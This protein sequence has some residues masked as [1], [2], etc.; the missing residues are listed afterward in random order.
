MSA[1]SP[2]P[3]GF[4]VVA[5][6]QHYGIR[7]RTISML[8]LKAW[9]PFHEDRN[10]S[11]SVNLKKGA[12]HCF[13]CERK[14]NM[15]DFVR[16]IENYD[17]ELQAL[18]MAKRISH[19]ERVT[20]PDFNQWDLHRKP[21]RD[22]SPFTRPAWNRLHH[23]YVEQ[24]TKT[25]TRDP[26]RGSPSYAFARGLLPRTLKAFGV[27]WDARRKHVIFPVRWQGKVVGYQRRV[28]LLEDEALTAYRSSMG[29]P[30]KRIVYWSKQWSDGETFPPLLV[31]GV[32]DALRAWQHGWKHVVHP[33]GCRLS[34]IQRAWLEHLK[35]QHGRLYVAMDNDEEGRDAE[36]KLTFARTVPKRAWGANDDVGALTK[37]Q[38]WTSM[39]DAGWGR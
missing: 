37:H 17:N 16:E 14:G 21:D 20:T 13:G 19:L 5:I 3:H 4:D 7:A 36:S 30:R 10:P 35:K 15:I 39:E 12:W 8:D 29:L 31:E 1:P 28:T 23:E 26:F 32:F 18:L 24:G 9:C 38:F 6:L 33:F 22:L 27:L 2:H 25:Y 34:D 11:L